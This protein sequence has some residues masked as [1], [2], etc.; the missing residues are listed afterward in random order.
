VHVVHD[1][2]SCRRLQEE[3]KGQ[4]FGVVHLVERGVER[5]GGPK[6]PWLEQEAVRPR[7]GTGKGVDGDAVHRFV[8]VV[9]RDE[10]RAEPCV[11]EGGELLVED[12]R[13]ERLVYRRHVHNSLLST[14]RH[15]PVDMYSQSDVVLLQPSARR[16]E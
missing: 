4:E 11:A 3:G 2:R 15:G 1:A 16:E 8:V 6:D 5:S 12:A 13:I 10:M 9:G 7:L 14:R